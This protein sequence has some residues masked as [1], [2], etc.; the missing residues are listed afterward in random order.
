MSTSYAR[1]EAQ[2]LFFDPRSAFAVLR[3]VH[4]GE[5]VR[6]HAAA[7]IGGPLRLPETGDRVR[8]SFSQG[9]PVAARILVS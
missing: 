7:F 8:V 4:G 1:A 2:V 3:L 6:L 5:E 9:Q